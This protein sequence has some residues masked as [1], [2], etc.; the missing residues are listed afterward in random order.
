MNETVVRV[1]VSDKACDSGHACHRFGHPCECALKRAPPQSSQVKEAKKATLDSI[2]DVL[3]LKT[4]WDATVAK[5]VKR[6]EKHV[7]A[8]ADEKLSNT[9]LPHHLSAKDARTRTCATF[10][11]GHG[12]AELDRTVGEWRTSASTWNPSTAA[13]SPA[14]QQRAIDEGTARAKTHSL[15]VTKR[16]TAAAGDDGAKGPESSSYVSPVRRQELLI[17]RV[18]DE[19]IGSCSQAPCLVASAAGSCTNHARLPFSDLPPTLAETQQG[20]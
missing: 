13:L 7:V 5:D 19:V 8:A 15:T 14:E 20:A 18:R 3:G 11:P 2:P 12:S 9:L 6:W 16:L 1:P 17:E 10:S 4:Q